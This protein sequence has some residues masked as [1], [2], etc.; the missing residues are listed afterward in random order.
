MAAEAEGRGGWPAAAAA[1]CPSRA[2]SP[3]DRPSHA[4]APAPP[5]LRPLPQAAYNAFLSAGP[6]QVVKE[7]QKGRVDRPQEVAAAAAHAA[8]GGAGDASGGPGAGPLQHD[9][10]LADQRVQAAASSGRIEVLSVDDDPVNQM[11][12]QVGGRAPGL[13]G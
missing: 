5:S 13:V 12:I 3:T 4:L 9:W 7:I 6:H 8:A 1:A 2:R 10:L 11:V